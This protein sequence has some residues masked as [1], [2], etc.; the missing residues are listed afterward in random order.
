M[1]PTEAL[2]LPDLA[3]AMEADRR[4]IDRFRRDR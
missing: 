1:E 3:E 2:V 4:E